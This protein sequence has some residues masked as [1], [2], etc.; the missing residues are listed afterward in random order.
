MIILL[1]LPSMPR[2]DNVSHKLSL[3][4]KENMGASR[5]VKEQRLWSHFQF[6]RSSQ[7]LLEATQ[8]DKDQNIFPMVYGSLQITLWIKSYC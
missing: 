6:R 8:M 5:M 3:M 7:V 1:V 2:G 4:E